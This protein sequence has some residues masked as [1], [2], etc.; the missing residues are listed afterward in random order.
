[1]QVLSRQEIVK[2]IPRNYTL[3]EWMCF[4]SESVVKHNWTDVAVHDRK[5]LDAMRPGDTRLWIIS[6][7]GSQFLPL[8]CK[9][10]EKRKQ[11][12]SEY[13]FSAIEV[14]ML[15]FVKD[16]RLAEMQS[17]IARDGSKFYF[18]TKGQSKYDHFVVPTDYYN[19]MDLVFCGKV[20]RFLT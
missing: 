7:F 13:D 10:Y 14:I 12:E 5:I 9:L 17:K 19:V 18:I 15:R 20:N 2:R 1:M 4:E 3:H 6:E 8:Y 16:D 11:E